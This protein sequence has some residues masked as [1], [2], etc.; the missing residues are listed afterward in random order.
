M[1]T[2]KSQGNV[3][4]DMYVG[5]ITT[6]PLLVH[7]KVKH[8]HACEINPD[9]IEALRKNKNSIVWIPIDTR[10]ITVIMETAKR[11]VGIADRVCLGFLPSAKLRTS[12][13]NIFVE[14]WWLASRSVMFMRGTTILQGRRKHSGPCNSLGLKNWKARVMHIERV[15]SYTPADAWFWM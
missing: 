7:G 10:Y 5:M 12:L 11:L 3:V 6:L 14:L 8:V 1:G 15:K 2:L 4:V 9:S 13:R